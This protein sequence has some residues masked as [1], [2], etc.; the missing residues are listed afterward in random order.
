[1]LLVAALAGCGTTRSYVQAAGS[2]PVATIELFRK[3]LILG[4][5]GDIFVLDDGE[6]LAPNAI[7]LFGEIRVMP[8]FYDTMVAFAYLN[9]PDGPRLLFGKDPEGSWARHDALLGAARSKELDGERVLRRTTI[10]GTVRRGETLKWTRPPGNLRVGVL[11]SFAGSASPLQVADWMKVEAG[12]RYR[13]TV[14]RDPAFAVEE[15]R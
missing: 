1:M 3:P 7:M 14:G 4:G 12:K 2:G 6:E 13:I 11:S 9:G 5:G 10:V 8:G 15:L